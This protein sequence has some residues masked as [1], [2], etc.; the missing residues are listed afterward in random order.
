MKYELG[1]K[2][3]IKFVGLRAKTQIKKKKIKKINE[4]KKSERH[5]KVC[6]KNKN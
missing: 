1:G 5:K 4:D 2:I 6:L 3:M